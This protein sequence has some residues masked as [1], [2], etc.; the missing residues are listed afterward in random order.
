MAEDIKARF[1]EDFQEFDIKFE[2][3]DLEREL[4]LETAVWMSM[5]TDR[6]AKIDDQLDDIND[7]RGWWGD[8]LNE[9]DTDIIGSRLWL[10]ARSKTTSEVVGLAKRYVEEALDW[11]IVDEVASKIEVNASRQDRRGGET[12]G[13]DSD[14]LA[15][16]VKVFK[17]D[18]S[19]TTFKF[20]DL[21]SNQFGLETIED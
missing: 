1:I 7:R 16:Q 9:D 21:W 19:A 13:A 15:I 8:D 12:T 14:V 10:L 17:D 6:R 3:G 2:N 5:F 20:D 18:G 11:L 4:G